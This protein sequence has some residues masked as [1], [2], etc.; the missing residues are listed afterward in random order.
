[1]RLN[2]HTIRWTI[3][4]FIAL[5]AA[6]GGVASWCTLLDPSDAPSR[7]PI[8][9][10]EARLEVLITPRRAAD[11][12]TNPAPG[13]QGTYQTGT[14][15]TI[16]VSPKEGWTISEWVGPVYAVAGDTAKVNM[17]TN[18]TVNV[19]LEPIAADTPSQPRTVVSGASSEV[20]IT[21]GAAPTAPPPAASTAPPPA[22]D[23]GGQPTIYSLNLE[24]APREAL[25]AGAIIT[26]GMGAFPSGWTVQVAVAPEET[27]CFGTARYKFLRW[28]GV[29][30]P[31]DVP[32]SFVV[33]E[34]DRTAVAVYSKESD[35]SCVTGAPRRF[36]LDL[37]VQP[38]EASDAGVI[39]TGAGVYLERDVARPITKPVETECHLGWKY[40]FR[41]WFG[42]D[43]FPR[44][45]TTMVV[46]NTDRS[47]V[48]YY[49]QY[50][51]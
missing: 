25:F 42:G 49:D 21:P 50:F 46:M 40:V 35:P 29:D 8:V 48:A 28:H 32:A 1:M 4:S 38:D 9:T 36:Q 22:A 2:Q 45:A 37:S 14:A 6:G 33:L 3:G 23:S 30:G 31:V 10:E 51:C 20:P 5:L 26:R 39:V 15:V 27:N 11:F 43:R 18:K 41:S 19:R 16:D 7:A 24:V 12:L 34:E 44:E 47:L 17:D 13:A